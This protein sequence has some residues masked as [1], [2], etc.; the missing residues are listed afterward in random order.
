[1]R[2]FLSTL[3]KCAHSKRVQLTV[4]VLQLDVGG[5]AQG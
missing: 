1:V 2:Y 4:T 3:Y 5:N